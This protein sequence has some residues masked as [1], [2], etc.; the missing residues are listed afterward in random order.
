M[1]D[2]Y[3][4][5]KSIGISVSIVAISFIGGYLLALQFNHPIIHIVPDDTLEFVLIATLLLSGIIVGH[6]KLNWRY[7][8]LAVSSAVAGIVSYGAF[9]YPVY[10]GVRHPIR[11]GLMLVIAVTILYTVLYAAVPSKL[12]EVIEKKIMS[13]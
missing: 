13:S 1:N 9:T 4:R 3:S 8:L 6:F 11:E 7:Y 10:A 2:N 12:T 5:T